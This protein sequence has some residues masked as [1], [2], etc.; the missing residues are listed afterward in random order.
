MQKIAIILGV[1]LIVLAGGVIIIHGML[2]TGIAINKTQQ[3]STYAITVN[4]TAK[5]KPIDSSFLNQGFYLLNG[6]NDTIYLVFYKPITKVIIFN[7]T[8]IR[9]GPLSTFNGIL[10]LQ[11]ATIYSELGKMN[12]VTVQIYNGTAWQTVTLPV[13]YTPQS[14]QP[15]AWLYPEG[16]AYPL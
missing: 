10:G 1:L 14:M 16:I 13:Y 12:E 6:S 9:G 11:N 3:S 8:F 2:H 5:D 7:Q 15:Y 4:T